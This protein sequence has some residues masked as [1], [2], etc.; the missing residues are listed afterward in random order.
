MILNIIYITFVL[1]L[2]YNR[3]MK[4]DFNWMKVVKIEIV[5][6]SKIAPNQ[7]FTSLYNSV[8]KYQINKEMISYKTKIFILLE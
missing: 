3:M 8:Q 5:Y 1:S 4:F 6:A 7:Y 2:K